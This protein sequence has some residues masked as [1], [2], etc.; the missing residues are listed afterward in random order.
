MIK[1]VIMFDRYI[2][3]GFSGAF[4]YYC[5]MIS[6]ISCRVLPMYGDTHPV[7]KLVIQTAHSNLTIRQI[8]MILHCVFSDFVLSNFQYLPDIHLM[9]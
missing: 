9:H 7:R 8:F 4:L 5:A 3:M 1:A 2:D 6:T